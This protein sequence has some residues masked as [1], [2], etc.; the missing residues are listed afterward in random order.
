MTPRAGA[1]PERLALS[2]DL[3]DFLVE[4]SIA[5]QNRA[6]YPDGHPFLSRSTGTVLDRLALLL[7]ER[8]SLSLGVARRQLVIEGVATDPSHPVLASLANKLHSHHIGAVTFSRDLSASELTD[9]L[10]LLAHEPEP[11]ERPLGLGPPEQLQAW[12]HVRLYP[13]TYDQLQLLEGEDEDRG[14]RSERLWLGLARAAL[15][16]E[17]AGGELPSVEPTVVAQAI[18][19]HP[20]AVAYD[21]VIVGYLLQIAGELK[22]EAGSGADSARH[23][24][25]RMVKALQPETLQRLVQMGG[26]FSQRQAFVLDAI[27]GFSVDA[28]LEIVKAAAEASH[29]TVSHAF[30][31]LL[32]KLA[33]HAD[34]GNA[35]IRAE[36]DAAIRDQVRQLIQGWT[37][38][39]PNPSKYTRALEGMARSAPGHDAAGEQVRSPEPPQ[40][41]QMCL[42][43]DAIGPALWRAVETM[44]QQGRLSLLL[45]ILEGAPAGNRTAEEVWRHAGTLDQVTRLLQDEPVDFESLDRILT[46]KGLAAAAPL[47]QALTESESRATRRAVFDRLARI[48]PDVGPLVVERLADPRWYVQRNLLALLGEFEL[49]PKGF[50]PGPWA[51]H[52]DPRV[53][54]EALKLMLRVPADRDR[55][56]CDTLKDADAR[57]AQIGL[58]AAQDGFPAEAV[59]FLARQAGNPSLSAEL[60]ALAVRL[61]RDSHTAEALDALLAATSSGK[62][63]VLRR[64]KLRPKSP[65]MLAAL[66]A[67]EAGWSSNPRAAKVLGRARR[68]R[69]P[70]VRAVARGAY[71]G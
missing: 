44:M 3:S 48:G 33:V 18:N 11:G 38:E 6:M 5:L 8:A 54:R 71:P 37:L 52:S 14:S 40:V 10:G 46:K 66:A 21:Q 53:R 12:A 30:T 45:G 51:R 70:E 2:R 68:S 69:D 60:R 59:P 4:F 16:A 64:P 32:S 28:V 63:L 27:Q 67:L 36:A 24:I 56:L 19:E 57:I 65:G 20:R 23:R 43:V 26:D 7:H 34:K 22:H 42:E 13:L 31:R 62:T 35:W 47:L 17:E 58:A 1:T 61:L 49:W 15:A 39:D 41:L 29:Q 9:V 55:A 50:Y 25:S